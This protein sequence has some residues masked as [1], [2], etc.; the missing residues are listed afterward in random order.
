MFKLKH[1]AYRVKNKD[2]GFTLRRYKEAK[3]SLMAL[4]VMVQVNVPYTA[5]NT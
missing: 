3:E 1:G 4:T 2:A 5:C